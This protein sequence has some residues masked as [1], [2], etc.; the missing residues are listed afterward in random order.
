MA[1]RFVISKRSNG[2]F[3]FNLKAGN[4][5]VILTSQGYAD[6]G[7]C[8]NG[9]E[10]VKKNSPDDGRYERKAASNGKPFFNLLA[11]N[12]QVIGTSEL[13][14]S[15]AGRENGI[16]SVKSNAPDAAVVDETA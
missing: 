3:Q 4:G 9:I 1:G 2:D 12:G 5:Q 13:Y 6:K 14:E 16:A 8:R 10:S 15:E 11:G 7:G